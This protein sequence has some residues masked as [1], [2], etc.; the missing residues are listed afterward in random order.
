MKN[1]CTYIYLLIFHFIAFRYQKIPLAFLSYIKKGKW[2]F[3]SNKYIYAYCI[4][5]YMQFKLIKKT[6]TVVFHF[7]RLFNIYISLIKAPEKTLYP[8]WSCNAAFLRLWLCIQLRS[9]RF[10]NRYRVWDD[11]GNVFGAVYK[12]ENRLPFLTITSCA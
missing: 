4:I 6:K 7:W 8:T 5:L 11:C 12:V 3:L 2:T 9:P 1:A 10:S